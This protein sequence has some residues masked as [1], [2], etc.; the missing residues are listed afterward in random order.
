MKRYIMKIALVVFGVTMLSFN[1]CILDAFDH[2]PLNVPVTIPIATSGSGN[3]LIGSDTYCL[4]E[5]A[6]VFKDYQGKINS[7]KFVQAAYRTQ[8]VSS[9]LEGDLSITVK[10]SDG[11]TLFN[12][13]YQNIKP[14]DY[15]PPNSPLVLKLNQNQIQ[16]LDNYLQ[17]F[18]NQC[19]TGQVQILVTNGQAPYQLNAFVDFVLETDTNL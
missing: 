3:I 11:N 6:D 12:L 18:N 8:S 4:D 15:M 5:N 17:N 9:G 2:I 7:V 14:A 1:G 10:D 19:L 13:T 16:A